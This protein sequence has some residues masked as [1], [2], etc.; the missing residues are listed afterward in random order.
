MTQ[1]ER[2]L[3]GELYDASDSDLR[4]RRDR[5][6]LLTA[7]YNASPP[8]EDAGRLTLLRE[9][10]GQCGD[11]VVI[12]PPFYCDYGENI[13]IGDGSFL[14]FGCVLLDRAKITLGRSVFIAP[15]VQLYAAHHPIVASERIKGPEL[16]SPIT[17]GDNVWLGGGVIVCPGV[18]I[19][20]NTT[21]GAGSV[22]T[23]D[24]PAGVLAAGNPCR[25]VRAL[26]K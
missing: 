24:V 1:R 16:A 18:T 21:I 5:A 23:R 4:A 14:N 8:T 10:L 9:L 26:A 17:I 12:E 19:G 25:V 7:R 22:V 13:E 3:A 20:E 2:M 6:R 15:Y 11:R